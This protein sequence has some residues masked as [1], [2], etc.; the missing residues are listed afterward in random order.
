MQKGY[1]CTMLSSFFL[2]PNILYF[3]GFIHSQALTRIVQTE[4]NLPYSNKH[5]QQSIHV[6]FYNTDYTSNFSKQKNKFT[7]LHDDK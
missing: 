2:Q 4:N 3:F 7:E 6:C 1:E 5:Q